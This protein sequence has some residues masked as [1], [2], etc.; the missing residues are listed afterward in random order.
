[1]LRRLVPLLVLVAFFALPEAALARSC[2]DRIGG[3]DYYDLQAVNESCTTARAVART[4]ARSFTNVFKRIT[5]RRHSCIGRRSAREIDGVRTFRIVCR[6]GER[7][8]TWYVRPT[9]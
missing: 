1:M 9:A 7:R 3:P 6:R 5:V 4:W 8:A 2:G